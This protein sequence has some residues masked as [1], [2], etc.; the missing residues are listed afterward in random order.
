MADPRLVTPVQV[1]RVDQTQ[2]LQGRGRQ[3]RRV[4]F[5]THHDDDLMMVMDLAYAMWAGRIESPLQYV[6]FDH[7][8]SGEI[9]VATTLGLWPDVDDQAAGSRHRSEGARTDAIESLPD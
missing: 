8:G 9:A 1:G 4:A 6:T 5:V 2:F 3:A 7:D